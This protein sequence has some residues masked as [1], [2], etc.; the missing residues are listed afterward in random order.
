MGGGRFVRKVDSILPSTI[1]IMYERLA[2]MHQG[3]GE[4]VITYGR[5]STVLSLQSSH[6]VDSRI[7]Y[8][9]SIA[10]AMTN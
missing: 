7:Y 1:M 10:I 9:H 5:E 2:L 8:V 3:E 6:T 4:A